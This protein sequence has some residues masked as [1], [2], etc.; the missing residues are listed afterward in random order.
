M[1]GGIDRHNNRDDLTCTRGETR[2]RRE[3]YKA[4]KKWVHGEENEMEEV[5]GSAVKKIE[6]GT[7]PDRGGTVGGVSKRVIKSHPHSASPPSVDVSRFIY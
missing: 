7:R 2:V 3:V 4:A 5:D 1:S 6:S